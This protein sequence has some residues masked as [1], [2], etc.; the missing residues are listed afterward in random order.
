MGAEHN[1]VDDF[2]R[3]EGGSAAEQVLAAVESAPYGVKKYSFN[4]YLLTL[5]SEAGIAVIDNDLDVGPA[6]HHE[7][8]LSD[9]L[10]RLRRASNPAS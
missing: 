2:V 7:L 1:F 8:P 4:V 5:D 10:E 9:F 6:G 3:V